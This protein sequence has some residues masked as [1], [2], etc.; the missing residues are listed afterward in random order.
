MQDIGVRLLDVWKS[1][2]GLSWSR[3][4]AAIVLRTVCTCV[5]LSIWL[6]RVDAQVTTTPVI[7]GPEHLEI[8]Q[9]CPT[10]QNVLTSTGVTRAGGASA[11]GRCR[12][13]D[14]QPL[15]N[16]VPLPANWQASSYKYHETLL[17]GGP[18]KTVCIEASGLEVTM[19]ALLQSSELG[20][21]I[22]ASAPACGSDLKRF[23]TAEQ[24]A[25]DILNLS[26][27]GIVSQFGNVLHNDPPLKTCQRNLKGCRVGAQTIDLGE[28]TCDCPGRTNCLDYV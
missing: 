16:G 24:M 13:M 25:S 7:F 5:A 14:F 3:N 9:D 17:P 4:T 1:R 20:W 19:S 6:L 12:A 22:S 26:A 21:F 18:G 27:N 28:T 8:Q 2:E 15:F 11:P 23:S 10:Y